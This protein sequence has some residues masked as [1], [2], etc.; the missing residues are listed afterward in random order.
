ML[1]I[2]TIIGF[3]AS[4]KSSVGR[5]VADMSDYNFIDLDLYIE[6]QE[7]K[8]IRTIFEQKGEE[9]FRNL[10]HH[11]LK[12][13]V[14]THKRLILPL[15]GGT[16]CFERNW[17]LISQTTSIY[18]EKSNDALFQRLVTRKAKRPLIAQLSDESLKQLIEGKIE[19][20]APFYK[21]ATHIINAEQSKK[22]TARQIVAI[23]NLASLHSTV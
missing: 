10:E 9:Y 20:R 7:G 6:G 5:I 2:V 19:V 23:T 16:P 3:M 14:D 17:K 4:G 22:A 15:G 13:L 8:A 12:E 21:R 1:M 18:L 11:Y